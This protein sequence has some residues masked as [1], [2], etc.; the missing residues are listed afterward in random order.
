MHIYKVNYIF[1][2]SLFSYANFRKQQL[3][4]LKLMRHFAIQSR[5]HRIRLLCT[6]TFDRHFRRFRKT[7]RPPKKCH[8][9]WSMLHLNIHMYVIRIY[10]Y[11]ISQSFPIVRH[12]ER[13]FGP[14]HLRS[15]KKN[16]KYVNNTAFSKTL[17]CASFFFFILRFS[18]I[19]H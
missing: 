15:Y 9:C 6:C 12:D 2:E 11:L 7:G 16:Y 8:D 18:L 3:R 17:I 13:G 19:K 14:D 10:E 1:E 5:L 4:F